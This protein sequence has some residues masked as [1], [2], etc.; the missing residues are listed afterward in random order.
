MSATTSRA[1][2]KPK[3]DILNQRIP[4][5]PRYKHVK[6]TVDTGA[7]LSKYLEKMEDIK[8]NYR[9]R[10]DEIFRRIKVATFAQLVIQVHG[11]LFVD[12][13]CDDDYY[14]DDEGVVPHLNLPES[15]TE[16]AKLDEEGD[17]SMTARSTLSD[18]VRGVGEVPAKSV[19]PETPQADSPY[20]LLDVRDRDAYDAC[21]II[22]ALSYPMAMLSRSCNYF[23][24]EILTY[25]NKPGKIIILYDEDE[26]IAP[27]AATTFVQR[28]VDNVFMLSGGLKVLSQK[29]PQGLV[30]GPLPESCRPS[31]PQTGRATARQSSGSRL[32]TASSQPTV[33]VSHPQGFSSDSLVHIQNSLDD[34]LLAESGSSSSRASSRFTT[35]SQSRLASSARST[36]SSTKPPPGRTRP[37]STPWK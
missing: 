28:E 3:R 29:F 16:T 12:D 6:A 31:P 37:I 7:S 1:K 2:P 5:N 21:H 20:L 10:K 24:K 13:G 23:T 27:N 34:L 32:K 11:S 33:P 8:K 17:G 18:F 25:K 14:E 35:P 4:E 30:S 9:Y 36:A 22:G 19:Q 26:R 15:H